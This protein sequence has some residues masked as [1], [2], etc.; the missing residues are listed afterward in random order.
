MNG[1]PNNISVTTELGTTTRKVITWTEP[2][3]TDLSGTAT[4]VR[5]HQPGAEFTLGVTSVRY[6]FTDGSNNIAYCDFSVIIETGI[7]FISQ[8]LQNKYF[9][10]FGTIQ[11][12][13][14][15]EKGV[16]A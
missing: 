2:T 10:S 13:L 3:A 14:L 11:T 6:T 7:I 15:L 5:S 9:E 4:R 1:C 16:A 8:H 12:P